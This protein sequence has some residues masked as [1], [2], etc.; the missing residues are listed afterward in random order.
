MANKHRLFSNNKYRRCQINIA[1]FQITSTGDGKF[2]TQV[3]DA[4]SRRKF[5][6]KVH[7]ASSR[8][9]FTT[10]VH[11][12]SSRRKFTTQVHAASSQRKFTTQMSNN[13]YREMANKHRLFSNN[14]YRRCQ[15][16]ITRFQITST[17][18]G[19]FTTQVHDTSSQ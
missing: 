7:D 1:R 11:D 14:K 15:I 6:I 17:G 9:R 10:Q 19:K 18:N 13:K 8:H 12:A 3:H 16:N 4:S 2:T 5:T